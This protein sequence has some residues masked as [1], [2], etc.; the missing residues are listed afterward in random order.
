MLI[1]GTIHAAFAGLHSSD[2]YLDRA[3]LTL[4]LKLRFPKEYFVR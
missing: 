4:D 3:R 2:I 1:L